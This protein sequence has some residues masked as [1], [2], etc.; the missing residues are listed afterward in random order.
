MGNKVVVIRE[1]IFT[2]K[3][4]IK[5]LEVEK[6]L[7][8]Y[9]GSQYEIKETRE[10]IYIGND[11]SD[12]YANSNYTYRLKGANAKAKA[13]AIQGIPEMIEIASRISFEE[14]KKRKHCKDARYGWYRYE[15]RFALPVFEKSGE[16]IRYNIFCAILLMRHAENDKIYLYDITEIK[17]E[18][19]NLFQSKDLTQ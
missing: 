3:R 1:I 9:V 17:K 11:F 14:N 7:K 18:T 12:E 16:V 15:S 13:N 4:S 19:S 6:Y 8:K 10:K 5:W 2:G